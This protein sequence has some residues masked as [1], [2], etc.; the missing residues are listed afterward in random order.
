MA[1]DLRYVIDFDPLACEESELVLRD[2]CP[3]QLHLIECHF[4]YA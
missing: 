2:F 3:G 4:R 1:L